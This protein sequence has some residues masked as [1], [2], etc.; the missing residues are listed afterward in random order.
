MYCNWK[1]ILSVFR[2]I[3]KK[4]GCKGTIKH[5]NVLQCTP[6]SVKLCIYYEQIALDLIQINK[7]THYN[8]S[9]FNKCVSVPEKHI[10]VTFDID[11]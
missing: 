4:K 1:T 10:F 5:R 7:D 3:I 6:Q 11:L 8:S 2:Y 9:I